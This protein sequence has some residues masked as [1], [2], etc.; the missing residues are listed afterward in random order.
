MAKAVSGYSHN[1]LPYNRLG[2][3]PKPLVVFEGL[4]F[5]HSPKASMMAHS[6]DFLALTTLLPSCCA[7]PTLPPGTR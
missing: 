2:D 4:T 7:D 6:Y 3:G 5:E 1:G